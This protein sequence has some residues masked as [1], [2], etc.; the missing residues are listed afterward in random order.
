MCEIMARGPPITTK[1]DGEAG[2]F[3]GD[4]RPEGHVFHTS[5]QPW[6]KPIIAR[7]LRKNVVQN[8]SYFTQIRSTTTAID[9][10][11]DSESD[12]FFLIQHQWIQV[13]Y[14]V[15]MHLVKIHITVYSWYIMK[16]RHV[17]RPPLRSDLTAGMEATRRGKAC[18]AMFTLKTTSC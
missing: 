11:T 15:Y 6:L 10:G 12:N 7:P 14:Q 16:H 18:T 1:P 5:R 13:P 8:C 3:C 9:D 17:R 4:R 2:G